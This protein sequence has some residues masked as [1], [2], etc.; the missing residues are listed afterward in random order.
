MILRVK[1]ENPV[2]V[3]LP[4]LFKP[5]KENLDSFIKQRNCSE[6]WITEI[7]KWI[8]D[9]TVLDLKLIASVEGEGF[10]K[11]MNCV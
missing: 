9:I 7:T 5:S 11:L 6:S 10:Q 3:K 4:D 2:T 8:A 1:Y